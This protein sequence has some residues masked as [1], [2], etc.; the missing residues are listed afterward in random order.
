MLEE[1]D[2]EQRGIYLQDIKQLV[3]HHFIL[4]CH[5]DVQANE[6]NLSNDL[7]FIMSEVNLYLMARV[8]HQDLVIDSLEFL[9]SRISSLS[10]S[11]VLASSPTG[12]WGMVARSALN[13]RCEFLEHQVLDFLL[14]VLRVEL[15]SGW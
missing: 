14:I 3:H 13:S 8:F 1:I 7:T 15:A 9:P 6:T 12:S 4:I 5:F 2:A 10:S 11:Y